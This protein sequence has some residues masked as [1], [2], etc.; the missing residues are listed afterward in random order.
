MEKL[1]LMVAFHK[2]YFN[3][4]SKDFAPIHVGKKLSNQDLGIIGDDTG[5]NISDKNKNFCELT[6]LY[7]AWKNIDAEYYGLMHYRR[8]FMKPSSRIS[9]VNFKLIRKKIK[10]ILNKKYLFNK[11]LVKK[12]E[13][14]ITAKNEIKKLQDFLI[15]EI[16][17]YDIFIPEPILFKNSL[18]EQFT[19]NHFEKDFYILKQIV[20]EEC[21][22]FN[23]IFNEVFNGNV[24]YAYNMFIMKSEY[25]DAY[26]NW[27]FRI[28][29]KLKDRVDIS[30]YDLYQSRLFGFIS[31]RLFTVYF[32]YLKNDKNIKFKELPIMFFDWN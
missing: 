24:L 27:L 12:I 31:E 14:Q 8:Y 30:D 13:N 28:L 16:Q 29:F 5:E 25:W 3:I 18:K 11:N 10:S 26:M 6:A 23:Q 15:K 4:E 32:H 17:N 19:A 7:W 22:L 2:P 1:F 21:P 9:Q 20:N